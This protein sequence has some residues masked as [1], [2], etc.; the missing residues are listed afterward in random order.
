MTDRDCNRE[1]GGRIERSPTG[2]G[3]S[4]LRR[5]GV[6][7]KMI[8]LIGVGVVVAMGVSVALWILGLTWSPAGFLSLIA[9]SVLAFI[10][11]WRTAGRVTRFDEH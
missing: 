7:P 3:P 11:I 4:S 6:G 10:Q 9:A 8:L 5:R 2:Q 1:A